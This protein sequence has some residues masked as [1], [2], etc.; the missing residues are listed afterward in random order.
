M[1]IVRLALRRPYTIAVAALVLVMAGVLS[2][3]GMLID[4]FPSIDIP[5]V[6]VVWSYNG[7]SAE[8]MERKV[9][10]LTE[11]A[12]ST[13]VNG[14]SSI[15]SQSLPG[16]SLLR[17]HFQEGVDIGIS[18]AQVV[19][20]CNTI[21]RG[22][23]PGMTPPSVIQYSAANVPVIQLVLSSETL[24][25]ER[26]AD[27]AMNFLRLKLFTIP[28]LSVPGPYGGKS[29]Q[30]IIDLNPDRMAAKGLAPMD[31][32][33]ALQASNLI[34]PAGTARI[35]N[36][37]FNVQVNSS[38]DSVDDFNMIPI[39]SSG[40]AVV[41]IGDVAVARDGFADQTN[42]VRI[43]GKRSTFLNLLKKADAS[44][45]TVVSKVKQILPDLRALAPKGMEI[46]IA[47]DQSVFVTNAIGNVIQEGVIAAL[48]VSLM[49]IVFLGSW[50]SVVI[51][52]TSIPLAIVASIV[53]LKLTGN[54]INIMTLGGLSLA[55][56]MLVDD[57]T[58]EVENIHRLHD[59]GLPITVAI[60]RGA[61]Q[62]ALPA[63][64]AT[65]AI[66]IVFFPVVLLTGPAKYL[67][68]PMALAVV[69][70]M[71]ASYLLSRTVVPLLARLL[72]G[73]EDHELALAHQK[74]H[75]AHPGLVARFHLR[76]EGFFTWLQ[77]RY[78]LAL[79]AVMQQRRFTLVVA[80]GM[81][82]MSLC[83]PWFIGKDFFPSTDAGLMKM[84]IRAPAGL[85][86]ESMEKVVAQVE[87]IIAAVVPAAERASVNANIGV[88]SSFNLAFVPSENVG[89]MDAELLVALRP[90]HRPTADY[91]ARI[92]ERIHHDLPDLFLQ[93][94]PADI[95]SQVINFGVTSPIDIQMEGSDLAKTFPFARKLSGE[96]RKIRGTTDV[97][98]R[99]V[100][101][102]PT[103]KLNVDRQ[104]AARLGLAQRDVAN[105]M[106]IGLSS[107]A[108]VAPSF[109][110]NPANNVNYNVVVKIPLQSMQ[111]VS[112]L[113]KMPVTGANPAL[114][115]STS[116]TSPGANPFRVISLGN[117]VTLDSRTALSAI[118][119]FNVQRV[120]DVTANV[121]GRDLG[122]VIDEVKQA[123]KKL[124]EL[125]PGMHINIRGQAEVMDEAFTK[126]GA[127]LVIAIVLVYLL[128]V[129]LFQ[130]WLD[131]FI[132]IFAVPGALA[133]MLWMLLLTHTTI[134]VE[135]F[136]GTIMAVG[137]A[138]SNSILLVSFANELRV[139]RQLG[140]LEAA[141]E[142]G[143][144]RLRP[145]LMT[146]LAM[147]FGMLPAALGLGEGGEQNAPLGRAVIGGLLVATVVTL[148]IVPI[149]Y[150]ILRQKTPTLH[151]MDERLKRET[152]GHP[153]GEWT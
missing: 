110:I 80:T 42:I 38:P 52:C 82:A 45:L 63:I 79:G 106:L 61:Q 19:S 20:I 8:E 4:I 143:R 139:E 28:G 23:P 12:L 21:V 125:P 144:T 94:M 24:P 37:E 60:L 147:L 133:G 34:L 6:A 3:R 9:T 29:R 87:Q 88:P 130:S 71:L 118:S 77:S 30:I 75:A 138:A 55:V 49:V 47:F 78:D 85:R 25:E 131:P 5:V 96:L 91:V 148:F 153:E 116:T 68:T 140:P 135:S 66:C 51:I 54:S 84:H 101:D 102:Y 58:V 41:S 114:A 72:M 119:H 14:I 74:A 36:T 69:F 107:S 7:L 53:G 35:A 48:L 67:F 56:G 104:R 124:G 149:I 121:E 122:G 151:L 146:A 57:A 62:I 44:T 137:I 128:M 97:G 141:M 17:I 64:M 98:I 150:S 134:N 109:Y 123:I 11:R 40:N 145:V 103:L 83:L 1:W 43:D 2:L 100:L 18:I 132:V 136:M 120:L 129:V 13:T 113:L 59:L 90:E 89:S 115:T 111:T 126:L 92:R 108:V 39:K 27:Y 105:T 15:E 33:T 10:F 142:A 46:D 31:V 99:Q 76:R 65:L 112:D 70:A 152:A 32:V 117:L 93:F 73:Q 86:L 50:R 22:M 81:I 26:I 16:I 127:G 95:V